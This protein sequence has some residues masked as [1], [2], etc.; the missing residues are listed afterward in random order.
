MENKEQVETEIETRSV[1]RI[2]A[3][4]KLGKRVS[5][6]LFELL[7]GLGASYLKESFGVEMHYA[8][9]SDFQDDINKI[10]QLCG[11]SILSTRQVKL[12]LARSFSKLCKLDNHTFLVISWRFT[13]RDSAGYL[14]FFGR[15][16]Y[17]YARYLLEK[18]PRVACANKT[19]IVYTL[20][21]VS[22]D[23]KEWSGMMKEI[24][25]RPFSTLYLDNDVEQKIKSHLD[26]WLKNRDIYRTRGITFK[27]GI[28]LHGSPGTG[29]SS[30]AAAIADYLDCDLIIIDSATFDKLNL[31]GVTSAIE[32]DDYMYV[33]LLD[34]IDAILASRSDDN[35]TTTDKANVAKL[36]SFL[37]SSNSPDNVVFVATTNY[38]DLLDEAVRRSGRFD[39]IFQIDNI[40]KETALRMCE[41]FGL[42]E[43]SSKDLVDSYNKDKINPA[44]L[45]V[46]ILEAIKA[47]LVT[48]TEVEE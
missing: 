8:D 39:R 16:S 5:D 38:V 10:E 33:V 37:D 43:S 1:A 45:Q 15:N 23:R 26:N 41:G 24:P 4:S 7:V 32:A 42:D 12:G 47:N 22:S 17:R 19:T 31:T 21:G 14:Y 25:S 3:E 2:L 6:N 9:E 36:L 34:D 27:T 28:L 46:S 40:S 44:D 29:K 18:Q 30:I 35:V 20:S 48:D 13:F 11:L